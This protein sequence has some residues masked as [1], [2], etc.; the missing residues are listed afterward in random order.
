MRRFPLLIEPFH[1]QIFPMSSRLLSSLNDI[2]QAL[3]KQ[4]AADMGPAWTATRM[5]NYHHGLAR[6]ILTPAEGGEPDQM[7][8]AIFL[9]SYV[10]ADGA[11][12]L[13]ASLNWHGCESFP[14]ISVFAKP[15]VDW[16]AEAGRI[17]AAWLA[18][19]PAAT[20]SMATALEERVSALAG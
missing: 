8:G 15:G 2:E 5:V 10:L 4:S 1:T 20:I 3:L 17:A 16:R 19:P 12:S 9:Q 18:G 13:K 7:R 11:L 14:V 6:M